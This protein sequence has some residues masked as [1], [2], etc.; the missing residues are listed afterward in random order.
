M[1]KS[2]VEIENQRLVLAALKKTDERASLII[3]LFNP[4]GENLR[5]GVKCSIP[6][7]SAHYLKLTD[8]RISEIVVLNS[9]FEIEVGKG[10]I[11]TIE[12]V[13]PFQKLK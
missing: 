12:I 1:R 3:R 8:E 4:T 6:L 10:Q 2:F 5:S 9:S 7:V 13:L 11:R